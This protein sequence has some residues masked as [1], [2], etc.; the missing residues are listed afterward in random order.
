MMDKNKLADITD[1]VTK[2]RRIADDQIEERIRAGWSMVASV[3]D[4]MVTETIKTN[5]YLAA[6]VERMEEQTSLAKK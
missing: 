2:T 6:I 1:R 3:L 4:V 5:V